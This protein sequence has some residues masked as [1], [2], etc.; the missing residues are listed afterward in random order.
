MFGDMRA[1][2]QLINAISLLPDV[3]QLNLLPNVYRGISG[4]TQ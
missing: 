4:A 3:S 1:V 2:R